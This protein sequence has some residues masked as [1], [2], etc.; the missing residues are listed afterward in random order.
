MKRLD[1]RAVS[2]SIEKNA[3]AGTKPS[4]ITEPQMFYILCCA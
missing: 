4:Q 1:L 2:V 3:G